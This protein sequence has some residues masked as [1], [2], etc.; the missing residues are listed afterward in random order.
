[1]L[2]LFQ[3]IKPVKRAGAVRDALAG[4]ASRQWIFRRPSATPGSPEC[5]SSPASTLFCSRFWRSRP[6]A[7][8]AISSSLPTQRPPPFSTADSANM[9]PS[10]S[11]RYVALAGLVALLTAG[12]LLLAR[13]LKLG[14]VADFLSRTVLVGLPHR[15][16][17]SSRHRGSRPDAWPRD[18]LP[19]DHRSTLRSLPQAT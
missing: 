4:V 9:A 17:V 8:H 15:R 19:Q 12:F 6:S 7:L 10:A 18:R 5:P 1:M 13:L 2:N 14:F 11:A 3:G 16:R